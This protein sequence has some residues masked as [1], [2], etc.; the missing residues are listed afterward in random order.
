MIHQRRIFRVTPAA[1]PS[2][3]VD[4]LVDQSWTLCTAFSLGDLVFANDAFS[5]DGAQEYAVVRDG[6]Q[7]ESITFS[8]IKDRAHPVAT[9]EK[10]L[11]GAPGVDMGEVTLRTNHPAGSNSCPLCA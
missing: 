5:E 4:K 9:I 1:S 11:A 8:W 3:L 6:R 10:M 2:E 7:I